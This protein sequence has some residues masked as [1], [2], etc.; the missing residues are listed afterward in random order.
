MSS[1]FNYCEP[2]DVPEGMTI[3]EYRRARTSKRKPGWRERW[4]RRGRKPG[5]PQTAPPR[6]R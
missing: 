5:D 2:P 6:K 1:D 3:A 4:R